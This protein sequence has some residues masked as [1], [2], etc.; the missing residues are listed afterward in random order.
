[1]AR[2]TLAARVTASTVTALGPPVVSSVA[3]ASSKRALDRAGRGSTLF[4]SLIVTHLPV[5]EPDY[6]STYE[7]ISLGN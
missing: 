2:A 3:A 4:P 1:M 5:W 6:W 7:T